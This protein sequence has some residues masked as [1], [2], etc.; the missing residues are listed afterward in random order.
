MVPEVPLARESISGNGS[1]TTFVDAKERLFTVSM[2]S[3]GLTLVTKEAGSGREAGALT[4]L[5]L[6]AVGLQV[7][8][9]KLAED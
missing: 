1:L 7:R 6:A 9:N 8:V 4:R 2:E 3:V 5:S